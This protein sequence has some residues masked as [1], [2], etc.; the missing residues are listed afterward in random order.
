[1][2]DRGKMPFLTLIGGNLAAGLEHHRAER[3]AEA[4]TCYGAA[5][6]E[7]PDHPRILGLL[8]QLQI[9]AGELDAGLHHL[10]R[11]AE[12]V[13][14]HDETSF[15]FANGC[16]AAGRYDKA[17]DQYRTLLARAPAHL[18]AA[19]NLISLLRHRNEP[20]AMR[21]V[22][23]DALAHHPEHP[24][25]L[26][27]LAAGALHDRAAATALVLLDRTIEYEPDLAEAHFLRGT[28]LN[29]EGRS[30]EALDAQYCAIALKPNH[31]AAHLNLGNALADLDRTLEAEEYC[32][33]ALAIDPGL[34]EAYASLG[35][36]YTRLGRLD[37]AI[38]ACRRALELSPQHA[39]AHWNL[40]IAS[41]LA[42]DWSEGWR[43]YEWRKCPELYAA[44]FHIPR[45]E[46]WKGGEL[47]GRTLTICA[48]QGLGD[49]IQLA[50]YIPMLAERGAE[51]ILSCARPL[52]PLFVNFPQLSVVLD[53]TDPLPDADLWVD[54]MSLPGLF[55]TLPENIP[56]AAGYIS[57]DPVRVLRWRGLLP[58]GVK[59]G[60]VWGGNPLHSNDRRRSIPP[61]ALEELLDISGVSL[62]SVQAGRPVPLEWEGRIFNAA[63]HLRDFAET[64]ACI[65]NL[66]FL[67]AVD[68]SVV[69]LAGAMGREVWTL[70]PAAPDWR[71]LACRADT[72]WYDSMRLF[73]QSHDRDWSS[74][75]R[76]VV[77]ALRL[78]LAAGLS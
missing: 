58:D 55:R 28:A 77:A 61:A 16:V 11:A 70:L 76:E 56:G 3:T 22:A 27:A 24:R 46:E 43:Q 13:P 51:L 42:G 64:A 20:A 15:A 67:I 45:G 59:V 6:A 57:A 75:V 17:A 50:R 2:L 7:S 53:R 52:V 71:W 78:R 35:Y 39:Y 29:M 37:Q 60:L 19:L 63:P 36:I 5:L 73:R 26:L 31:A 14:E 32:R 69:H 38:L 12:L 34:V 65:A 21:D 49:A 25:L 66:D 18:G 40:G 68:T 4:I 62:I 8:G 1:M 74:P 72:P 47:A 54:Q 23:L 30:A 48:E 9:A 33:L 10:E 41:L 44:H